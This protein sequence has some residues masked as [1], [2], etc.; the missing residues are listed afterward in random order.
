MDPGFLPHCL[1]GRKV[2]CRRRVRAALLALAALFAVSAPARAAEQVKIGIGYG[3]AFLPAYI[4]ED[5]KLVEKHAKAQH[6]DLRA[7]YERFS[8]AGAIADAIRS[9]A[10]DMGP[11]GVAPLLE[12]WDKGRVR[13]GAR[14]Q[15]FAVSG[16]TTLPL[17][18]LSDRPTVRALTD[19]RPTDRIAVPTLTSPQTFFLQMQA[20][21]V[22]GQYD[23]LRGELVEMS[24][25]KALAALIAGDNSVTAYFSSP[26]YTQ[27]ALKDGKIHQILSSEQVIGG[28]ASL[29]VFGATK[30]YI[31]RHRQIA[32]I[33]EQAMDDAAH[34]IR[35]DPRRAAR[36]FLTYE[37]SKALKAADIEAVLRQNKDEFGSAV[38][39]IGAFA[40]FMARHGALKT[41]PQSWKDV[42]APALLHSPST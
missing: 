39:G 22:F 30:A 32:Q 26:P 31:E 36:I 13:N 8:G 3:L 15:I 34:L 38:A 24:H 29:L 27:I 33:L 17:V 2:G 1:L 4:C 20:E 37:P 6:L 18:L 28:K 19:L 42:V 5:L 12:A 10:L 25:A 9:R 11:F 40:E 14:R 41:P 16:M 7:V 35:D 21:K 23:R